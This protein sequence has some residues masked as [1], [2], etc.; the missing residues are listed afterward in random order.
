MIGIKMFRL[1]EP[2]FSATVKRHVKISIVT[3]NEYINIDTKHK[4]KITLMKTEVIFSTAV[5]RKK[6]AT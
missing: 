4:S 6:K 2:I 3:Q 5:K 1:T